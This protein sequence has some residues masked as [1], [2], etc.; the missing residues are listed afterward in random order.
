MPGDNPSLVGAASTTF[1]P[2]ADQVTYSGDTDPFVQLTRHVHVIGAEGSKTVVE[3]VTNAAAAAAA[4]GL[5]TRRAPIGAPSHVVAAA[6]NNAT[7]LKASAGVVHQV[8][9]Y[10]NADYPVYV[11]FFNKASAPTPGTD[12]V[13]WTVGV[14]AGQTRDVT[15]PPGVAFATGI[16]MAIVRGIADSDNTAVALSDCVC[17]VFYE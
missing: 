14:Q 15:P 5:L 7:S 13:I 1:K 16:A 11:K 8:S 3:L 17:D 2:A 4:Y 10:N 6:S 12:T 9:V